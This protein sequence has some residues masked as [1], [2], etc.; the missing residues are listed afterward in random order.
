[1]AARQHDLDPVHA[2]LDEGTSGPPHF[3]RA[4][5]HYLPLD[6]E[7]PPRERGTVPASRANAGSGAPQPRPAVV[8]ALEGTRPGQVSPVG[9]GDRAH[10]GHSLLRGVDEIRAGPDGPL[11]RALEVA[12]GG[13]VI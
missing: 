6:L 3:S 11:G 8:T 12:L 10:A 1:E 4:V 5:R 2:L 9:L 13:R 7:R